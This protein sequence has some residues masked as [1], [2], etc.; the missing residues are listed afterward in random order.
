MTGT[1]PRILTLWMS[2]ILAAAQFARLSVLAPQLQAQLSL[3]L[4]QV[5]WLISLL[6]V[7]GASLGFV[8][9]L[10]LAVINLRRALLT[11]LGILSVTGFVQAF[12]S[13]VTVLF[14]TRAVEGIGY[15]L[16]VI[17]APTAIA[18][19]A[20]DLIR[21][22][23]LALWSTFVPVGIAVGAGITGALLCVVESRTAM[24]I[25]SFSIALA[26]ALV[27][28]M[29]MPPTTRHRVELPAPAAWMSTFGFG[30]YTVFISALTMLLPSF[31][32]ER[33][34]AD[35]GM[36]AL[37]A[38]L[39]SLGALPATGGAILWMHR[40]ALDRRRSAIISMMS[41][42]TAMPFV[43]ALYRL[44]N[45][46]LVI[47]ATLA[48]LAVV[49]SGLVPPITFARLPRLAGAITSED[50]KIAT[51][52]GL[53]TQFGAGGALIGPPLAGLIVGRWSWSALGL[54]GCGL[55]AAIAIVTVLA[56][57]LATDPQ[58]TPRAQA[59]VS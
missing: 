33:T 39:A 8:A 3:T 16:V 50:P 54:A 9:G 17:A 43:L 41:V 23:A 55:L 52:N 28:R 2:G 49:V 6:E 13:N 25:W 1:W 58:A 38:A 5:G 35:T 29:P 18:G 34:G 19:V 24:L 12:A 44:D 14:A 53:I 48:V 56:E 57:S 30:L 51:A 45:P 36:A 31:L 59:G 4:S 20:S 47:S 42:A 7:G 40:H 22:R 15:L 32:I 46:G 11:G 27:A 21:P 10:L 26:A 37:V